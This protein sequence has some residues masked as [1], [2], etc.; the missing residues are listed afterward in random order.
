MVAALD[1]GDDLVA[2]MPTRTRVVTPTVRG[3]RSTARRTVASAALTAS[4]SR[5]ATSAPAQ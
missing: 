3:I 5:R 1:L 4:A 2:D